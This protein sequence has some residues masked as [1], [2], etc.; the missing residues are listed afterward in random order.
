M[1]Y[2]NLL[3][4]LPYEWTPKDEATL[5]EP[6]TYL[7]SSPGKEIRTQLLRAFNVWLGCSLPD[8]EVITRV[9]GM[10]HTASLL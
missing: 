5:L 9:V 7:L 10:L 6:F 8:L 2:A 4:T 1:D 3:S